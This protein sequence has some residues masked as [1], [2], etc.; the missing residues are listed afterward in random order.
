MSVPAGW[1]LFK[2]YSEEIKT[3]NRFFLQKKFERLFEA[4]V[5]NPS[6]KCILSPDTPMFRARINKLGEEFTQVGELRGNK[7]SLVSN[8]AS[9]IG[10]SYTYLASNVE[11]ALAE[12][13][14][15]VNQPVTVAEFR[16]KTDLPFI[17][18]QSTADFADGTSEFSSMEICSFILYLSIAFSSPIGNGISRDLDYLPCQYFAEFCKNCYFSGIQ[19]I[20]AARGFGETENHY[21]YVVFNDDN[22]VFKEANKFTVTN[23]VHTIRKD[24]SVFLKDDGEK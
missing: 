19:Y 14:A 3:Q 17:K 16:L 18:L 11:T 13:R 1:E 12:I 5:S 2:E 9:P 15:N 24:C 10:I 22:L 20:S 4:I 8:R 21:N 23:I 7:V 6:N